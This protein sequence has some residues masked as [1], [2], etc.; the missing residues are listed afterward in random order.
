MNDIDEGLLAKEL[1]KHQPLKGAV[2]TRDWLAEAHETTDPA[3]RTHCL[4]EA[5]KA[6]E[7]LRKAYP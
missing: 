3:W 4:L 5:K 1:S 2:F 7:W 6:F